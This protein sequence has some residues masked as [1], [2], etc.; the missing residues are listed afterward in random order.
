MKNTR[1]FPRRLLAVL[2]AALLLLGVM[3]VYAE[4]TKAPYKGTVSFNISARGFGVSA[5]A[6]SF[7]NFSLGIDTEKKVADLNLGLFTKGVD[8]IFAW[9]NG[10]PRFSV[11]AADAHVYSFGKEL[12]NE[13]I[14]TGESLSDKLKEQQEAPADTRLIGEKLG[15][16]F[17]SLISSAVTT[18]GEGTYTYSLLEAGTQSGRVFSMKLDRE[19]WG[20]F[21]NKCF[22]LFMNNG[23]INSVAA[24][25]GLPISSEELGTSASEL[26]KS[27]TDLTADWELRVFYQQ[28]ALCSVSLGGEQLGFIYESTGA[29]KEGGRFDA[30]GLREEN[31]LISLLDNKFIKTETGYSGAL[32]IADAL[33][34]MYAYDK[35]QNGMTSF[36][37][38]FSLEEQ[39]ISITALSTPG[40]VNIAVPG[41]ADTEIVDMNAFGE[42]LSDVFAKALSSLTIF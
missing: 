38:D 7:L 10:S 12:I 24:K 32:D 29:A 25:A 21:W 33:K 36:N 37:L 34:I 30:I 31:T 20:I 26:A 19:Q 35:G 3:P 41:A 40:E 9:D 4:E 27:L 2:L 15:E 16:A 1:S 23:I 11:P 5:A 28:D 42:V 18:D 6:L 17:G 13:L 8:L 39:G 22:S 14:K